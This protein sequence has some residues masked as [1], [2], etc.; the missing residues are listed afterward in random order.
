[1]VTHRFKEGTSH[2]NPTIFCADQKLLIARM[3]V[4]LAPYLK[5]HAA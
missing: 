4:L 5:V 1:M 2:E 3:E